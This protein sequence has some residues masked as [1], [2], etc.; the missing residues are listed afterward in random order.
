MAESVEN[1]PVP[2]VATIG[3]ASAAQSTI[4]RMIRAGMSVARLNFSHGDFETHARF[5]G[6]VRAAAAAVGR[7]VA[8]M[9]DLPGPKMRIGE[10]AFDRIELVQGDRF[11]LTTEKTPGTAAH[12]WVTFAD[13]PRVVK[14][15]DSSYL[16]AGNVQG[17]VTAASGPTVATIGTAGGDLRSR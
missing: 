14:P 8:I 3:P 2:I 9:A 15:G 11:T 13:L 1:R 16:N 7:R 5:I 17:E 12:V 6:L 10:I 4:E